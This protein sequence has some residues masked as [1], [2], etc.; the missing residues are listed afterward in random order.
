MSCVTQKN[1]L[2]YIERQFKKF[3]IV[4]ALMRDIN[5]TSIKTIDRAIDVLQVF[6]LERTALSI[7]EISTITDIPKNT[8]YRILYTLERRGL[9]KFDQESLTYQPG[10]RLIEF[11]FL[12]S[13]VMDVKK[14]AED[15]LDELFKIT[16]QTVLM[17]LKEDDDHLFYIFK[18]ESSEGLKVSTQVG[19]RRNIFFGAL[20]YSILAFLPEQKV[21]RLLQ[22]DFT[23]SSPNSVTDKDV[24]RQRLA[25]IRKDRVYFQ[26]HETTVG[27]IGI[28]APLFN[29][30]G[31]PIAAIGVVGPAIYFDDQQL[32]MV[33]QLV[34][35]C[36]EKI[37]ERMGYTRK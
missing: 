34:K 15:L 10:L 6:T 1:I 16:K 7:E 5:M 23:P 8:V 2:N 3:I 36:S 12:Q 9:I 24:I 20:G 11:G 14:E 13:A 19:L 33:K 31:E 18:R 30:F 4:G 21:E 32:E 29:A 17:A 37:S 22:E 27:V 28:S 25:Q 35:E 26:A